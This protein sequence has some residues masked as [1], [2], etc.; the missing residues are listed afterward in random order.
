MC[1]RS[2]VFLWCSFSIVL[3]SL[4]GISA[5]SNFVK[6]VDPFIGTDAHGHT[7]PGPVAPFG[8]IQLGPDTRLSG[9]DG[10]S[11]YHY[12]DTIIYGFSHTHLSGTGV[13]DYGDILLMPALGVPN[14]KDYAYRSSFDKEKEFASPGY[15]RVFL[16]EP[17]V[18][19]E[20][21]ASQRAG[22]HRYTFENPLNAWIAL[23]LVHRDPVIESGL[24]IHSDTQV[25]GFRRSKAWAQDQI[26]YFYM[27]FSKP[28][29]EKG[30]YTSGGYVPADVSEVENDDLR[31]FFRFSL[32]HSGV[33]LIKIGIS[34]VDVE[35]AKKNLEAEIPHWS[36]ETVLNHTVVAWEK[37]LS[38][39]DVKD[40]RDSLKTIFYTALYHTMIH[41]SLYTDVD[42]R[43]RGMDKKVHQAYNHTQYTVFSLWDTYRALHPLYNLIHRR[44][45]RDF[46]RSM[47]DI[48]DKGG[49][50]PVWELAANETFCMIGYHSVS[51][52]A[53]AWAKQVRDFDASL[54][55]KAMVHSAEQDHFGL[56]IYRSLGHIPGD[57]EHEG[58]SKTLEYAYNDWCIAT[59]A[60]DLG[61]VDIYKTYSERAQY[62]KN[63]FD[64]ETRLMRPRINGGW[65]TPFS[66]TEVDLHFTEANSW[67][68]SFYVPQDISGLV[69][70]HGSEELFEEKLDELFETN[71]KLS[72][73]HQVDITGLIGQYAHGNEP[74]HHMAYLYNYIGKPHKTQQ[75]VREILLTQYSARADGLCG[76]EDCGQMS[77]WYILSALG[78][79]P[80]CPGSSQYVIGAPLFDSVVI[81]FENG[82][83]LEII[84]YHQGKDNK[85]IQEVIWN[86]QSY[87]HSYIE[88]HELMPGGRLEFVMGTRPNLE[89]ASAH[90]N[91][92][93]SAI[94]DHLITP[95][96][97]F[98][99]PDKSFQDS[100][101]VNVFPL[102][103][104]H[105]VLVRLN[106]GDWLAH[107]GSILVKSR[108]SVEAQA[109]DPHTGLSS[110]SI[111]AEYIPVL[112]KWNI[113][114]LQS[115]HPQY[116]AGGPHG[117]VDGIRGNKNWRLGGWQGY[118]GRDFEVVVD[119]GRRQRVN[120]VGAGFCQDVRSWIWLPT[121]M[122]VWASNNGLRFN[123]IAE[124]SHQISDQDYEMQVINLV[125]QVNTRARYIKIVARN[126]GTIPEWHLG[127]GGSA[128]IF[129]DEIWI[130]E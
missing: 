127:S 93:L 33:I 86:G 100:L 29:Y 34:A 53:D 66:P 2:I 58:V 42:G 82:R 73:R 21:T 12:T 36:F 60:R 11:G 46:I 94:T 126:Y 50:L 37:E 112:R 108:K 90:E 27:E 30:I 97:W 38:K 70:L 71:E 72:G 91:R 19:V 119:L 65:K 102:D 61:N 88:H 76:N 124:V 67:Q 24:T 8:M 40:S 113:N 13:S 109:V 15:Y 14:L 69:K 45:N 6:Y 32:D 59:L 1:C 54:A 57:K 85:Y 64:P 56:D 99:R 121:K 28:F 115:Y 44:K 114:L 63:I 123:K 122:E 10:C 49:L 47:L 31:A 39:I 87:P 120:T 17:R 98:D 23:D 101:E 20:L 129:V 83:Q 68:Y 41:P 103:Q 125:A 104:E 55:L 7:F 80:V 128:F 16:N 51:V 117:I 77:A 95:I 5:Q 74:S 9:W 96:P 81:T 89:W 118:Q 110:K 130:N 84:A 25:S 75:R 35:G 78:F 79:Y 22:F 106:E 48:Y 52:I 4:Q 92:P 105:Q 111:R 116:T 18:K 62:Y 3:G 26:V 43:Y 107:Q